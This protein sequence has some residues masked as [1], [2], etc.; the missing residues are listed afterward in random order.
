MKTEWMV[1]GAF[2]VSLLLCISLGFSILFA[3]V[4]GLL[5]FLLYGRSRGFSWKELFGMALGGVKTV[6]GIL[7]TFLVIGILTAFW[8]ASGT[9]PVIVCYAS[10]LIRPSVFLL[11]SFLLNCGIS[12]LTGTSFGTAATMGVICA[13]MGS[14]MHISPVLTGGAILSGAFFGDRCSPLS[15]SALLV[16]TVTGTDIYHNIRN[17]VRTAVVPFLL[18]CALYLAIGLRFSGTGESA[19][20]KSIFSQEFTL[21]FSALLPA[22]VILVLSAAHVRVRLSMAVSILSAVPLCLFLQQMPAKELLRTALFGFTPQNAQVASM[23]SGGGVF[24][25]LNV[26][27]I[28]CLSSSYSD[29]FRKTGLLDQIRQGVSTLGKRTT[30]FTATLVTSV[31]SAMIACN[32]TLAILLTGQLCRDE[33]PDKE[34]FA[35]D[36]EDTVVVISALIPWSIAGAAPLSTIGAPPASMAAAFYLIL[37]PLWREFLSLKKNKTKQPGSR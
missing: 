35:L 13:S 25:M 2:C 28:V 5:I 30:V 19:D 34:A 6:S 21:H 23:M 32:Q 1:L 33:N 14:A 15:T 4:F 11:M 36:L 24:S 10:G 37:L 22:I 7:L 17:M 8:R 18:S 20:L 27:A 12:F 29:L 3:L 16:A 9:I 26:T 31:L